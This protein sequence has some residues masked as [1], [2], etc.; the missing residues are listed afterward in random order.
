[1]NPRCLAKH[2]YVWEIIHRDPFTVRRVCTRKDCGLKGPPLSTKL[3]I[4]Q[5]AVCDF[6]HQKATTWRTYADG[7]VTCIKCFVKAQ[8]AK[9]G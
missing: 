1:M 8:Q 2:D 5:S 9:A 6:C 4:L 7:T 3:K